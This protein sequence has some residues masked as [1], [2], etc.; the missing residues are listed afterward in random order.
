MVIADRDPAVVRDHEGPVVAS[1]HV[2]LDVVH[3]EREGRLEGVERVLEVTVLPGA[4]PVGTDQHRVAAPASSHPVTTGTPPRPAP[5]R[6]AGR[7]RRRS[8]GATAPRGRTA[9]SGDLHR[10]QG[11]V[12]GVCRGHEPRVVAHGLVVVAVDGERRPDQRA[13]RLPASVATA[14]AP[15]TSPPGLCSSCPTRSGVCWSRRAAGVHRHH[16]HAPADAQHRQPDR[17][18]RRRAGRAPRRRGP[19]ASWRCAGAARRRTAPGRRRRRRE[20][21]S[22]SSRATTA[23]AAPAPSTGGSSTGTPPHAITASAYC[24]GST[25]ARWSHTP[26]RACSR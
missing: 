6:P 11:A 21:T 15:N 13:S 14:T 3:P 2:E 9:P 7:R 16:L 18:R 10:L 8:P 23:S 19:G 1:L 25:S 17:V 26:H 4:E 24:A 22:P 5:A 12:R 20:I